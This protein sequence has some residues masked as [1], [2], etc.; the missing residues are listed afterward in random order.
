MKGIVNRG[1]TCWMNAAL[2]CLLHVPQLVNFVRHDDLVTR[3]LVTKRKNACSLVLAFSKLAK[4]YWSSSDDTDKLAAEFEAAFVQMHRTF[5]GTRRQHD[6]GEALLLAL[7]SFHSALGNMEH[8]PDAH[9]VPFEDAEALE[10]WNEHVRATGYSPIV[11]IFGGQRR[12][13][14]GYEQF[15]GV[16]LDC[17]PTLEKCFEGHRFARLPLIMVV[18]L[19][20]KNDKQFVSYGDSLT[21]D[22]VGSGYLVAYE[23][24][25]ALLHH[26]DEKGGHWTALAR[27]KTSWKYFDD[28]VV[29]DISDLN[30]LV[31]KDTVVLLYKRTL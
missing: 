2:Q 11:D 28:D 8:V 27:H 20:K 23:L 22:D 14:D 13:G 21:L 17:H 3:S 4:A 12:V 10:R 5:K 7:N 18:T 1:N 26:G 25:A 31:Q 16:V 24:F 15:T 19:N 6:A 30:D 29:T 9:P